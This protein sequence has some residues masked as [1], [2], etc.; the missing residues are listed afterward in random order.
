MTAFEEALE[1]D[2]SPS[3]RAVVERQG[4]AV[5]AAQDEVRAMREASS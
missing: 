3:L 5:R 2:I 1:R 4:T